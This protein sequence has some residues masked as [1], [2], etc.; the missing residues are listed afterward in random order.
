MAGL[1]Y[2]IQ[3]DNKLVEMVEQEYDSED[4]LQK[5]LS[6]YPNLLAGEQINSAAPRRWLLVQREAGLPSQDGGSDRWSVDHL[7]LDQEAIPTL[8]EVKRS[9]DTRIRREVVGQMLDYAANAVVYW[10]ME[11]IRAQFEATCQMQGQQ[12]E[13]L[14]MQFLASEAD[15]PGADP[16]EFWQG[17][18]TNLQAGKVRLLFVA[19]KIP[20]ELQRIVEFLNSQMDPAEVLAL[21]VKQYLGQG[22]KTLVPTIIGQTATAEQKKGSGSREKRQWDESSFLQALQSNCGDAEKEVAIKIL[23][24]A[25]EHN[26]RISWGKGKISGSFLPSIY[27]NGRGMSTIS[28]WTDGN[29]Q[30][31]FSWM[32]GNK[33]FD[34]EQK[35]LELLRRVNEST[36]SS[37]QP[38]AINRQP[39]LKLSIF[40][41]E[42]VLNQFLESLDWV[43]NEFISSNQD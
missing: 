31:L 33:P 35:R 15:E 20:P 1:I 11:R 40:K 37:L 8:V 16:E 32:K 41:N 36:G 30:I 25:T 14:L 43:I 5:L 28:V 24:W 39:T 3:D 10:P 23:K 7:F 21:E 18:K 13:E 42:A 26:L 22:L 34:D 2:L 6:Q 9:T 29:L 27:Y 17:V 19:D 4:L 12:P 38:E